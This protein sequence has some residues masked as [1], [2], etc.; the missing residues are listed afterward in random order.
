MKGY[1]FITL[2]LISSHYQSYTILHHPSRPSCQN[3]LC[4]CN[5]R[6]WSCLTTVTPSSQSPTPTPSPATS[7]PPSLTYSTPLSIPPSTH[8]N[9]QTNQQTNKSLSAPSTHK[10][11]NFPF[12]PPSIQPCR[13]TVPLRYTNP[14]PE[15]AEPESAWPVIPNHM[16]YCVVSSSALCAPRVLVE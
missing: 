9:K 5:P 6:L 3:C 1:V 12:P 10:P 8:T 2:P 16:S 4:C 14:R 15:S 11:I 13:A 7:L